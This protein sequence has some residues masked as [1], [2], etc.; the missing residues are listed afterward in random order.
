M[1]APVPFT[2]GLHEVAPGTFA[3]LQPDGGWGRS[4]AGLVVGE[5][6]SGGAVA[7]P[8]TDQLLMLAGSVFSV[9]G[10]EAGAAI[11]Y[12]D[13]T[14]APELTGQ[15]RIRPVDL[16]ELGV[17]DAVLPEEPDLVRATIGELLRT[18]VAGAR[19]RRPALAT[20]TA[21]RQNQNV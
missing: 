9:I 5:G 7:H 6:G 2:L 14:R 1:A 12:R 18:T 10:P 8:H 21:L 17:V 13:A 3:Y 4:N 11:L 19:D 15:L 20:A 16:L